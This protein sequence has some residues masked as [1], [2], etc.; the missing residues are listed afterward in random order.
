M[1]LGTFWEQIEKKIKKK[2]AVFNVEVASWAVQFYPHFRTTLCPQSRYNDLGE[3]GGIVCDIR[4]YS[5]NVARGK[6][7]GQRD[8]DDRTLSTAR[9]AFLK[10]SSR[11]ISQENTRLR[12]ARVAQDFLRHVQ[13]LPW[14]IHS[15]DLCLK[16]HV[17][18]QLKHPKPPCLLEYD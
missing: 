13:T 2:L 8:V 11:A 18:D 16:E 3:G 14:S 7:I 9:E 17:W 12:K 15:P 6:L 5:L 1:N 10:R 4:I